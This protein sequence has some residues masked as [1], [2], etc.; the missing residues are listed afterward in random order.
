MVSKSLG[1][2]AVTLSS[3]GFIKKEIGLWLFQNNEIAVGTLSAILFQ[4]GIT[5]EEF[6]NLEK[7]S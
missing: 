6:V 5:V 7:K 1:N 2:A 3:K 4:A